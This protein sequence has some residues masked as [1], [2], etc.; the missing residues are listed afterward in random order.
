MSQYDE[1]Q[2]DPEELQ[3]K[4][5]MLEAQQ[6]SVDMPPEMAPAVG[7]KGAKNP[8]ADAI[9]A[10]ML[11][12]QQASDEGL[13]L[14]RNARNENNQVSNILQ[15]FTT[16]GAGLAGQKAD[17]AYFNSLRDQNNLQAKDALS[18]AERNRKAVSDAIRQKM[19]GEYRSQA[20]QSKLSA[21]QE[22]KNLAKQQQEAQANSVLEEIGQAKDLLANGWGTTG[23]SGKLSENFPSSSGAQLKKRI[24][25]IKA[26][27]A[28]DKLQQM[29]ASSPTGGAL[30]AVSDKENQMLQSAL[31]NLDT[32]QDP[33]QLKRGLEK[34]EKT[35]LQIVHH[36]IGRGA[37]GEGGGSKKP[38]WAL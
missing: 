37:A 14:A 29:R 36:G 1:S 28:F 27:L 6:A 38:D 33:E 15:G 2:L 3:N 8:V 7:A 31:A 24:D 4:I 26:N 32:F 10:S 21:E 22:K 11:K 19:M 34:V 13:A 23:W 35:Y 5:A 16:L 30:G 9:L 25:T 12:R 18:D 17:P 20:L